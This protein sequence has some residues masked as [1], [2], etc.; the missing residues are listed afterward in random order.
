MNRLRSWTLPI[1]LVAV[2]TGFMLSTQFR[3]QAQLQP[4][5][6]SRRITQMA[7]VLQAS[8]RRRMALEG[9]IT[10]LKQQ[11]KDIQGEAPPAIETMEGQMAS[12]LLPVTGPGIRL[13]LD[14]SSSK[15][16]KPDGVQA[17]V[18]AEDLL[19]VVNELWAAGAEAIAINDQRIIA[20]TDISDAGSALLIN[21]QRVASPFQIQA[22]G[23][24]AS[25]QKA[26]TLKGGVLEY[27][28]FF[29][30][31]ATISK[32]P[33]IEIPA[34][35]GRVEFHHARPMENGP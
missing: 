11:L 32:L 20:Q 10:I 23:P 1:G 9:E 14:D 17:A 21:R 4:P 16:P 24:S 31:H 22:I 30:I 29:G 6:P 33:A 35:T 13:V 19:K 12:G 26:L 27:L 3:T 34:Y 15:P 25:L 7:Q 2:V 18:R 8:E 28:Q 5:T